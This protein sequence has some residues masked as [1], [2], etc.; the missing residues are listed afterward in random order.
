MKQ[1]HYGSR[2]P[3]FPSVPGHSRNAWAMGVM[4]GGYPPSHR[5]HVHFP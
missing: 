2:S 1:T 4:G 3:S 5:S